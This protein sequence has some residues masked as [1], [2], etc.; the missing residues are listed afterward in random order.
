M[1]QASPL[2]LLRSHVFHTLLM[3]WVCLSLTLDTWGLSPASHRY[4]PG[5]CVWQPQSKMGRTD[6]I[7]A[8]DLWMQV[9]KRQH[10][11]DHK[12]W[13]YGKSSRMELDVQ[14]HMQVSTYSS[15][16]LSLAV[17]PLILFILRRRCTQKICTS[18][19]SPQPASTIWPP[20]GSDVSG[21]R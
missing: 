15:P 2:S 18:I 4:P 7:S 9:C 13:K 16:P 11:K 20:Q 1:S 21:V 8:A 10:S 17:L 3:Q 19:P 14:K 5:S 12:I 6:S